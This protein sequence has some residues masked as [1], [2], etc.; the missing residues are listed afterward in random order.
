MSTVLMLFA[1]V[2][3]R[4]FDFSPLPPKKNNSRMQGRWA[5][6]R[7]MINFKVS[8]VQIEPSR[9]HERGRWEYQ[10]P[11]SLPLPSQPLKHSFMT[12]LAPYWVGQVYQEDGLVCLLFLL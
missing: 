2:F 9:K 3:S 7:P 6:Q 10:G 12:W 11:A 5:T 4:L 8:V 1:L